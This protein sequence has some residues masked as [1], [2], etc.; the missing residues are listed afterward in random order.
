M[1]SVT[2]PNL[3]PLLNHARKLRGL[4][5][6]KLA[7]TSGVSR[8]MLSQIERG[9]ASPTFSTL[10]NITHALGLTLADL[11]AEPKEAPPIDIQLDHFTPEITTP[12]KLCTL[13]ILSPAEATGKT[14]W[15]LL[16][17][18]AGGTLSSDAHVR[19]TT[20]HLTVFDGQIGISSAGRE[21]IVESGETARYSAAV[22]HAI[23]NCGSETAR[24][25]LVVIH[26]EGSL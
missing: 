15:Y 4:T 26:G 20:E 7:T 12:D 1:S 21:A 19:G 9:E 10:W 22:A 8:S 23:R 2:P 6:E 11:S 18:G 25:L 17:L 5:L 16:T 14:E 3:G 13:R 24:A